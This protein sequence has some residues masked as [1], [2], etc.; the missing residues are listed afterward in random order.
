MPP[1]G[2]A[3]QTPEAAEKSAKLRAARRE[4]L[5][6]VLAQVLTKEQIEQIGYAAWKTRA[7]ATDL[8]VALHAVLTS[9]P[10]GD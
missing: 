4:G 5:Q 1:R 9:P 10:K 8:G 2:R 3:K 7:A 6:N